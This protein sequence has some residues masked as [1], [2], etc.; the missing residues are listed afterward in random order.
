MW[1]QHD[2]KCNASYVCA[3]GYVYRN[4][5]YMC[6]NYCKHKIYGVRLSYVILHVSDLWYG[7]TDRHHSTTNSAGLTCKH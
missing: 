2:V 7:V 1:Y 6:Y 5:S 4:V 3:S